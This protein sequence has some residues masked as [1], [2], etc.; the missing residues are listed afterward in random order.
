M[1]LK[2]SSKPYI[3]EYIKKEQGEKGSNKTATSQTPKKSDQSID[4]KI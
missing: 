1:A 3:P 2:L 4:D